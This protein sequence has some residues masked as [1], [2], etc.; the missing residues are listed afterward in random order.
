MLLVGPFLRTK[1][2]LWQVRFSQLLTLFH[3]RPTSQIPNLTLIPLDFHPGATDYKSIVLPAKPSAFEENGEI[4][5][6]PSWLVTVEPVILRALDPRALC[7]FLQLSE[8]W[9]SSLPIVN[10]SQFTNRRCLR[11]HRSVNRPIYGTIF[12]ILDPTKKGQGFKAAMCL[13]GLPLIP[14][15]GQ[16]TWNGNIQVRWYQTAWPSGGHL[17]NVQLSCVPLQ[18]NLSQGLE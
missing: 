4:K 2:W 5:S 7:W 13:C 8:Y 9:S 17:Q 6:F 14:E 11:S 18:S 12:S 1:L 15:C 16:R 3:T 10:L